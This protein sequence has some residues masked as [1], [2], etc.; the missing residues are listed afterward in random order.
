[1]ESQCSCN[2]TAE[3]PVEDNSA[4][5]SIPPLEQ[6]TSVTL[7]E[8][9]QFM[10]IL[11]GAV[12]FYGQVRNTP[13][14]DLRV[15]LRANGRRFIYKLRQM[16]SDSFHNI[17]APYPMDVVGAFRPER[18]FREDAPQAEGQFVVEGRAIAVEPWA[19][20]GRDATTGLVRRDNI[21][22]ASPFVAQVCDRLGLDNKSLTA[23][24]L[25]AVFGVMLS[26]ST[27]VGDILRM[28]ESSAQLFASMRC[29]LTPEFLVRHFRLDLRYTLQSIDIVPARPGVD[30]GVVHLVFRYLQDGGFDTRTLLTTVPLQTRVDLRLAENHADVEEVASASWGPDQCAK[31][32]SSCAAA[33]SRCIRAANGHG[34]SAAANIAD[35]IADAARCYSGCGCN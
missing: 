13:G 20:P 24:Q 30:T 1:M 31:C 9:S 6:S 21:E 5:T 18:A 26:G 14:D 25:D 15:H 2:K 10:T 35:C 19:L 16:N 34:P 23:E 4:A 28:S 17:S 33:A 8:V 27:L 3:L 7:Q 22:T 11:D 32:R 29:A 12:G